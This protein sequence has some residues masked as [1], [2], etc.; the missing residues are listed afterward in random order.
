M[1]NQ[2]Y[3]SYRAELIAQ[4]VRPMSRKSWEAEVKRSQ[5]HT[6]AFTVTPEMAR[7]GSLPVG[8]YRNHFGVDYQLIRTER[9]GDYKG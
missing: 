9:L 5:P 7:I 8:Q 2:S 4:E 6:V 3:E 1:K